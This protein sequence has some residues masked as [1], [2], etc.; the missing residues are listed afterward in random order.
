MKVLL[1]RVSSATVEVDD[2]VVGAIGPG[3]L[4]FVGIGHGDTAATVDHLAR[5]TAR[6]RLFDD[7][8]TRGRFSVTDISG[9][10]LVVSQFTLMA[11]TRKGNRPSW[12]D[13]ADPALAERL[14]ERFSQQLTG[15]GVRVADGRFGA[16]MQVSLVNDGPVTI[17]LEHR[18]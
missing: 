15:Y 3:L 12:S 9:E 14:V 1:Q 6:I 2:A 16:H 18:G 7:G 11:D 4:A 8:D 13:A 17:L 5:K 10:I